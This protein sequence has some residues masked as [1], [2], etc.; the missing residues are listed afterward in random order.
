MH[1]VIV[2]FI[3]SLKSR[4]AHDKH[5]KATC[6]WAMLMKRRV[7]QRGNPFDPYLDKKRT[8]EILSLRVFFIDS[9]GC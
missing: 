2:F 6:P 7:Y 9:Q 5:C 8:V 3:I 1:E 4:F